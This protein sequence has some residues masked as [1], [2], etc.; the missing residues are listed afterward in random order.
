MNKHR[1]ADICPTEYIFVVARPQSNAPMGN[2][3]ANMAGAFNPVS[4]IWKPMDSILSISGN[5]IPERHIEIIGR[6]VSGTNVILNRKCAYRGRGAPLAGRNTKT[7]YKISSF[8]QIHSLKGQA[9]LNIFSIREP[10]STARLRV[11]NLG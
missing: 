11:K 5:S 3:S 4:S 7:V 10:R 1:S 2:W 8:V 6:R 9:Y